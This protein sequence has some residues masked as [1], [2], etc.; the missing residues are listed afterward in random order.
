MDRRRFL[1]NAAG[2]GF[3]AAGGGWL[4]SPAA[5][6][7]APIRPP[8]ALPEDEFLARCIRCG[9]CGEAC[10]NQCIMPVQGRDAGVAQGT[11]S[12]QP[13][14]QA[15][16]LCSSMDG[17]TLKC[18]AA[19]PTGALQLVRKD[20]VAERVAMGVAEIDFALCYSYNDYTCGVCGMAC[21]YQGEALTIG[22]RE[23]PSVN[24]DACVGCGACERA[25]IRYP[26]AIRVTSAAALTRTGRAWKGASD[27]FTA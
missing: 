10:P 12:I 21:P 13:R 11:P 22:M 16:M 17:D 14:R 24:P 2:V 19:C 9:R 6:R 23:R 20:D 27:A 3:V 26:Q 18:T 8:G 5:A 25:C 4:A 15:C 7:P 1:R